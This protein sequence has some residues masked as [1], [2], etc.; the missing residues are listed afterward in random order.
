MKT[1]TSTNRLVSRLNKK[2][3][4]NLNHREMVGIN[5][6]ENFL[7]DNGNPA[8]MATGEC[9]SYISDTPYI[10]DEPLFPRL[11]LLKNCQ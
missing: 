11:T 2:T 6:G 4:A 10:P 9:T 8:I 1:K 3:V 5:G 7:Q